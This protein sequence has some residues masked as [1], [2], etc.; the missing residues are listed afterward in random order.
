MLFAVSGLMGCPVEASDGAVGAVKDFLFDDETWKLRWMAVEAGDWLPGRRRVF[1]HP[2]AIAP[3]HIS[4]APS[5]PMMSSPATLRLTVKLARAQIEAGPHAH[6]DDP[7]TRDME[8]LL[9]DHY[10][11]DP[12]WGAGPFCPILPNAESPIV[13]DAGRRGAGAGNPPP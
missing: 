6:E 2:S 1:I 10:G 3:L 9:Y 12:Y 11:S 4:P 7:V 13:D 5:L 8:A